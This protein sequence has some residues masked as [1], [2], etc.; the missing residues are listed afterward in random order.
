MLIIIAGVLL[1]DFTT[2]Q[3]L[4][5]LLQKKSL[6]FIGWCTSIFAPI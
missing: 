3:S 1:E 4:L 6:F 2:V 5:R